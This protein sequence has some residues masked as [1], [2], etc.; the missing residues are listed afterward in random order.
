MDKLPRRQLLRTV[1][2]ALGL[3][4]AGLVPGGLLSVR[5]AVAQ[6]QRASPPTLSAADISR[7]NSTLAQTTRQNVIQVLKTANLPA[8]D[9][10]AVLAIRQLSPEQV[11]ESLARLE[12]FAGLAKHEEGAGDRCG[13]NC[14]DGCGGDCGHSCGF[15]CD[16]KVVSGAFCGGACTVQP[17]TVG[18][19]DVQGRLGINF[20]LLD[21]QRFANVIREAQRLAQ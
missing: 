21:G 17:D 1:L 16:H 13:H 15:T 18:M 7:L 8:E 4:L 3:G 19:V 9:R 11:R 5:R 10:L 2:H 20:R 6:I 12:S 14:G